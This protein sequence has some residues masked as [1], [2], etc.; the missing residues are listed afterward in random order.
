MQ[1]VVMLLSNSFRPDPRVLKE[2]EILQK[3]GFNITI[4]CWD[5]LAALQSKETLPSGGK[6]IRVQNIRSSY[7]IGIRQ[8][9]RLPRF[10]SAAQHYLKTIKPKLIHC[11]DFDTLPAGLWYGIFHRIPI[12]YDAHE[13]YA[14]LV[15]PRLR[16]IVGWIIF[17]LIKIGE[18]LGARFSSA[19]V[20]V[21]DTLAAIYRKHNKR[22]VILG[23]YPEIGMA[24]QSN[25][26]FTR[27]YLALMYAGRLSADRGVLLYA[28]ILRKLLEKKIP[29][30]LVLAGVFTPERE[31]TEF[32]DYAKDIISFI[33]F[34]GWISYDQIPR[35]YH[36]ADIGLAILLPEPRY[37]AATPVKLFEYMASG[38]PVIAS[39]FPSIAE[40][41][42]DA[43]CG[44]LIDPVGTLTETI[45]TIKF[46]WQNKTTPQTLGENGRNA[47]LSKYNWENN[48]RGLL[49]LYRELT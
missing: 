23:H 28:D 15:K 14:Q 5:R 49:E 31:K 4:I 17:F 34:L 3:N 36:E 35:S 24:Q 46:W 6:V 48:S 32:T 12:I 45:D 19:V 47:I 29:A 1:D 26:V 33:D 18:L 21:D 43:E 7:G 44:L 25:P 27:P 11:H 37:V 38:L 20:T 16:G 41:V 30:R 22:V 2:A 40:I 10:W 9:L 13:Y 42:N 8:L 39:N